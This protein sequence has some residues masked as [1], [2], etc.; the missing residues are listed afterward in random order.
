MNGGLAFAS[1]FVSSFGLPAFFPA[2]SELYPFV[3]FSLQNL[4][5]K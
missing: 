5:N 4:S 2:T 3:F 1:L